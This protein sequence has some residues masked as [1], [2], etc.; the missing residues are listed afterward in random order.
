M[1]TQADLQALP[2]PRKLALGAAAL[3]IVNS[4]LP[5]YH[6]SIGGFSASQSGWHQFGAIAWIVVIGYVVWEAAR[7]A[8]FAPTE[9]RQADLI[10]TGVGGAGLLLGV[11]FLIQ[12]I[13]DGSLGFAFFLGLV[14]L[15]VFG[16]ALFQQFNAAGGQEA[17]KAAQE[18]AAARRAASK[19]DQQPPTPGA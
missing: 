9:E 6:V 15:A 18:Q 5:W 8:K 12:R 10:S 17:L 19:D 16:Y 7:I 14:L 2:T 11:I 4:F 3:L 1:T 13:S